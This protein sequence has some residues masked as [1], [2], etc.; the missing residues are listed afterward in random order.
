[1]K[2]QERKFYAAVANVSILKNRDVSKDLPTSFVEDIADVLCVFNDNDFYGFAPNP[3]TGELLKIQP[4]DYSGIKRKRAR[5][6][7]GIVE[8]KKEESES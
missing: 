5:Q 3:E 6:Y 8:K 7:R 1:M 2:K 4:N